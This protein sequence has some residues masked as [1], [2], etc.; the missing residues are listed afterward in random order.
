MKHLFAVLLIVLSASLA[1]PAM[2][3]DNPE[4]FIPA[5]TDSS[6]LSPDSLTGAE[7]H[8]GMKVVVHY[9]H[10]GDEQE[11]TILTEPFF[12]HDYMWVFAETDDYRGGTYTDMFSL[13]GMGAGTYDGSAGSF[14][15]A[16]NYTTVA[17]GLPAFYVVESGDT[18]WGIAKK[19]YGDGT[20]WNVLCTTYRGDPQN[21]PIGSK[22][23][24]C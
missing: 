6:P 21:L 2:A 12:Y 4:Y 11:I 9:T 13:A 10:L 5:T 1:A 15:S 20:L 24:F 17:P 22:V 23:F 7:L 14:W 8:P 16:T 18:L 19:Y 3:Q